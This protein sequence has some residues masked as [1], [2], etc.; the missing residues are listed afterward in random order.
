MLMKI[1]PGDLYNQLEM[2]NMRVD[3]DNGG[4]VGIVKVRA[5]KYWR[6]S[7]SE[8][9]KNIVCII[10]DPNFGLGGLILLGNKEEQK[11][12]IYI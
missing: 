5:H 9:W 11:I 1:W 3:D 8:F 7:G 4:A 6:F 10:S 2:I 12:Y